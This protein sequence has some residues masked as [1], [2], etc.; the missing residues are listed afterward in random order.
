MATATG[1]APVGRSCGR[2]IDPVPWAGDATRGRV[3][4]SARLCRVSPAG[5]AP[6]HRGVLCVGGGWD[7]AGGITGASA[8]GAIAGRG[9]CRHMWRRG[10]RHGCVLNERSSGL[11]TAVTQSCIPALDGRHAARRWRDHPGHSRDRGH[12]AFQGCGVPGIGG[13]TAADRSRRRHAG[14]SRHS[15]GQSLLVWGYEAR[16]LDPAPGHGDVTG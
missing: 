14:A 15:P 9:T 3:L 6:V 13:P 10:N 1:R 7:W 5:A 11:G 12:A 16:C 8:R 4:S 2:R